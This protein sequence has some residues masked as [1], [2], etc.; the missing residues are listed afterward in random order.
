[1]FSLDS[2]SYVCFYLLFSVMIYTKKLI[3]LVMKNKP[4]T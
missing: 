1:M 3:N 2:E 4:Q